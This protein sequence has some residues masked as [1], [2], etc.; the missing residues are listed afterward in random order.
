MEPFS[1]W[2]RQ[3]PG[4]LYN[5][6]EKPLI[7][8]PPEFPWQAFSSDLANS[9]QIENFSSRQAIY[10]GALKQNCSTALAIA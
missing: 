3:I 6:D 2:L 4:E 10:S 1:S 5:L 9:L 8:F 7:G